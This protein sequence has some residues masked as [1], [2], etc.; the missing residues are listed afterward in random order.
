VALGPDGVVLRPDGVALGPDGVVLRPDGVVA[1]DDTPEEP[2]LGVA[3]AFAV[4]LGKRATADVPEHATIPAVTQP[5]RK[6]SASRFGRQPSFSSRRAAAAPG[7][8]R[9]GVTRRATT[10]SLMS[11]HIG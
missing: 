3:V 2:E 8:R 4:G 1:G 5:E 9:Q 7:E 10:R 11:F 6:A